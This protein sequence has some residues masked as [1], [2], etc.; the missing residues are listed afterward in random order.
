MTA[1]MDLL[2]HFELEFRTRVSPSEIAEVEHA[3]Q[4]ACC[5]D[6]SDKCAS[7]TVI[8]QL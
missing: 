2:E 8:G 1:D 3:C 5:A 4:L 6:D 7:V